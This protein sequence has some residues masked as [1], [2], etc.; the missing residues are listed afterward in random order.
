M[1]AACV[2]LGSR[3]EDVYH[4][5]WC[6]QRQELAAE[7]RA[8]WAKRHAIFSARS[9]PVKRNGTERNGNGNGA[10]FLTPTVY[11]MYGACVCLDRRGCVS[12]IQR[13]ELAAEAKAARTYRDEIETLKVQVMCIIHVHVYLP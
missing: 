4:V 9:L 10:F 13:Q 8:K 11:Y 2:C 5:L 7:E 3:S 6:P 12:C 1:Y